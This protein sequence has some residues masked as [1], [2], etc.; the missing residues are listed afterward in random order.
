MGD[1]LVLLGPEGD[2]MDAVAALHGVVAGM[3]FELRRRLADGG[4]RRLGRQARAL[5]A[6]A[7]ALA[8]AFGHDEEPHFE[9]EI[10]P[11]LIELMRRADL[12]ERRGVRHERLVKLPVEWP[13]RR[14]GINSATLLLAAVMRLRQALQSEVFDASEAASPDQARRMA[15]LA[16]VRGVESDLLRLAR[17]LAADK[18]TGLAALRRVRQRF[19]AAAAAIGPADVTALLLSDGQSLA[20]SATR[21][22]I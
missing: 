1:G 9:S 17:D 20:A 22:A 5:T 4:N 15:Q 16:V 10:A 8:G 11:A 6:L 21:T 19:K 2:C 12:C 14:L 3:A 13:F 18:T 7:T